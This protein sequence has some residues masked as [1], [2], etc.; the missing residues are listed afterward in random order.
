MHVVYGLVGL[1]THAKIM[2]IVRQEDDGI[3]RYCHIGTGNYNATTASLY[4][5]V[6]ILSADP[7]LG[8]DLTELFNALTGYSRQGDYRRAARRAA[9]PCATS[10]ASGSSARRR[11]VPSGRITL[12]MNS[13]V[14]PTIIDALYAAS[15]RGCRDRARSSAASAACGPGSP[16]CRRRSRVRSIIGRFLEHSRVYRFGAD[17]ATA[18]YLI[19]SADLMPRNLDR[20]VEALTPIADAAQGPPRRG[21]RHRA[22]RRRARLGARRRRARGARCP[23]VVGINT[24]ERLQELAVAAR[25]GGPRCTSVRRSSHHRPGSGCPISTDA[26]G[27][28][29]SNA[30]RCSCRP[31][32]S[33]PTT[34]GSPAPARRCAI[35][36]TT[37]GR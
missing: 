3:R 14:D 12:K 37:A 27:S 11:R 2:L 22:L 8:A 20:R 25:P 4:E 9:R 21:H 30:I 24:H 18:E 36:T 16:A 26:A 19:G 15:Q 17:P 29:P 23:T 5:D 34:S 6:G 1:K 13:L 28:S 35:A 7:E 32:T 33:T 10:S 31:P